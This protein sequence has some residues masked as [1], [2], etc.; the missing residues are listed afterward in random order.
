METITEFENV[1][2]GRKSWKKQGKQRKTEEEGTHLKGS[3]RRKI[4]CGMCS[5]IWQ[6]P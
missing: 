2:F 5:M 1:H 6:I 3:T 4:L